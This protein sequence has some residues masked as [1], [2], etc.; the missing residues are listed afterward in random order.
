MASAGDLD[1][2]LGRWKVSWGEGDEYGSNVIARS[3]DGRVVEERFD[4]RPGSELVGMSVSVLDEPGDRW[5]QSWVD[6]TGNYFALEGGP[7]DGE[8]VLH[9]DRHNAGE[10]E[11]VYRMRFF[12]IEADS[13]VWTWEKSLDGGGAYDIVWRIDYE[14]AAHATEAE[15]VMSSR[16]DV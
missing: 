10:R 16:A 3:H 13:F 1:F 11:A 9:C 14:R 6:N 5:L 8:F 7:A 15:A 12:D 4:G 2:W